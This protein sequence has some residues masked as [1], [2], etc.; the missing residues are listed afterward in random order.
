MKLKGLKEGKGSDEWQSYRCSLIRGC[1]PLLFFC[2]C[3]SNVLKT[4]KGIGDDIR[5]TVFR[6]IWPK[7][8]P[9]NPFL[10]FFPNVSNVWIVF[11]PITTKIVKWFETCG[12][13][14]TQINGQFVERE[15]KK[16]KQNVC[17]IGVQKNVLSKRKLNAWAMSMYKWRKI[18]GKKLWLK[19]SIISKLLD[20]KKKKKSYDHYSMFVLQ[21]DCAKELSNFRILNYHRSMVTPMSETLFGWTII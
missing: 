20:N 13:I 9:T 21:V 8:W 4:V 15:T 14:E 12:Q 2:S 6:F 5:W 18:E 19:R 7:T 11:I 3:S 10:F 16:M 17:S 1:F